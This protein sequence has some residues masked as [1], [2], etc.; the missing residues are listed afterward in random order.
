MASES[1]PQK[2]TFAGEPEKRRFGS[3]SSDKSQVGTALVVTCGSRTASVV[4]KLTIKTKF[5]QTD[6]I[7]HPQFQT[8]ALR[9]RGHMEE[10]Q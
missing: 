5:Q 4:N 8:R 2:K 1:A 6:N 3:T 7:R 9:H 10:H